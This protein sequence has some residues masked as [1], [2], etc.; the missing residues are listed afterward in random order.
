MLGSVGAWGCRPPPDAPEELDE[1]VGYLYEN[2][3]ADDPAPLEAGSV[4]LSAW[5]ESRLEETVEGYS[6]DNLTEAAIASLEDGDRDLT[7]LAGAA[8]GHD[9]PFP[10]S[11]VGPVVATIEPDE[12]FP[13]TY[14]SYEREFLT[15][16]ECF[17]AQTCDFLEFETNSVSKYALG[18]EVTTNSMVQFR[19]VET[20]LGTAL[21]QRSWLHTPAEVSLDWLSVKEQFYLWAFVPTSGGHRSIQATWVVAEIGDAEVPEGLALQLVIDSMAGTAHTLDEFMAENH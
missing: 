16:P 21:V 15:D 20:E 10:L 9:S 11:R 3:A 12:L 8:V 13:D 4:N 6:V 17:A 18:L 7:G 19:W 1:L 5:L 2:V 14:T